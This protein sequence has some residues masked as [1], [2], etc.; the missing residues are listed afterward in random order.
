MDST[1]EYVKVA[2]EFTSP[3]LL[4]LFLPSK[5]FIL[6]MHEFVG[7]HYVTNGLDTLYLHFNT[8]VPVG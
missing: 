8:T 5:Y 4:L 1:F 6:D 3:T 2:N 7:V